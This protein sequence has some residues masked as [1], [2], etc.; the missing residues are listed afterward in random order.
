MIVIKRWICNFIIP[1]TFINWHSSERNRF[2]LY[3]SYFYIY[4]FVH[5]HHHKSHGFLFHSINHNLLS[6][7]YAQIF[8][9][10]VSGRPSYVASVLYWH[11]PTVLWP[12]SYSLVWGI[13]DSSENFQSSLKSAI[14][15]KIPGFLYYRMVFR[16]L[17]TRC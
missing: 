11:C 14:F 5:L 17:R 10:L 4:V 2:P 8:P 15:G 3:L 9:H 16:K 7:F 1:S 12:F 13:S 6:L